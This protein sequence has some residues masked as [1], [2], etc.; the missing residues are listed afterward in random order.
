MVHLPGQR[1]VA[2]VDQRLS[3]L[4]TAFLCLD[5][6]EAPMHL[7]ALA[8]FEPDRPVPPERLVA[9]LSDRAERL[10]P[11]RRRVRPAWLAPAGDSWVEDER[12]HVGRHVRVHEVDEA[13]L[14]TRAGELMAEPL[15]LSR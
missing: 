6:P 15:D 13:E 9:L 12:F 4:D 3:G 1:G 8:V 10:G 7:G 11:L 5:S 2:M 14:A